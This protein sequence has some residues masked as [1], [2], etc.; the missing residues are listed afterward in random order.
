MRN[1]EKIRKQ[2]NSLLW[3]PHKIWPGL[4]GL[5]AV[6]GLIRFFGASFSAVVGYTRLQGFEACIEAFLS[7]YGFRF[8]GCFYRNL[9]FNY[10]IINILILKVKEF[11]NNQKKYKL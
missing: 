9:D 3:N 1:E 7:G 11:I 5:T 8:Y 6:A 2:K 4:L 10:I